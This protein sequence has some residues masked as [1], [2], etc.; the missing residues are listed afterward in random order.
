MVIWDCSI[1]FFLEAL[2]AMNF[3]CNSTFIVPHKFGYDVLHSIKSLISL[4]LP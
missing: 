4:F 2:S 1:F 3:P